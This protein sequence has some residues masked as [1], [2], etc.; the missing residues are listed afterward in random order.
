MRSSDN[1]A[2]L[3]AAL[4]AW[5]AKAVDPIRASKGQVGQN[6]EYKYAALD[7]F[8]PALRL[9]L[10]EQ[11]LSIIQGCSVVDG[12]PSKVTRI[13]HRT[14]Q[15]VET[16]Y[17]LATNEDPQKQGSADTYARR[18][19]LLSALGLA[20][21]DDDGAAAK[22]AA[23]N[24]AKE[25]PDTK[26]ARQDQHDASWEADRVA[27]MGKLCGDPQHKEAKKRGLGFDY[28]EVCEFLAWLPNPR[29]HP[30]RM[31]QPQRDGLL[32]W[33]KRE[34]GSVAYT[35]FLKRNDPPDQGDDP[36][37]DDQENP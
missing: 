26:R 24:R 16:D 34:E 29:P 23:P 28:D 3:A 10:A 13:L 31:T 27:F 36:Q 33:L 18:Y 6:R 32:A 35:E 12:R 5:A 22:S 1:I 9:E 30:S 19:G 7:D 37:P 21:V 20:P 11:G 25:D 2:D 14:G 15:W 4:A 17:P 8:L